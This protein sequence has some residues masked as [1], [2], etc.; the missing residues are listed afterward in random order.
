MIDQ[1]KIWFS[2]TITYLQKLNPKKTTKDTNPLVTLQ[3]SWWE[4]KLKEV[5]NENGSMET[6]ENNGNK[7]LI[8]SC[9]LIDLLE[10]KCV[11]LR[12]WALSFVREQEIKDGEESDVVL[13]FGVKRRKNTHRAGLIF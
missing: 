7:A 6:R 8:E 13:W 3:K 12:L 5:L 1:I 9:E 2:H 11:S 4:Y 10:M